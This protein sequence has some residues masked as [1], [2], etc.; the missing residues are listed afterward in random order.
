MQRHGTRHFTAYM[1]TTAVYA[2][3]A[4]LV[5][6]SQTHHFTSSE[7]P[8]ESVIKMSLSQFVPEILTPEPPEPIIEEIVEPIPE[9]VQEPEVVVEKEI[10]KEPEVVKEVVP[11][12]IVEKIVEKPVKKVVKKQPKPKKR[13]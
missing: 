8:K 1:I 3:A 13:L 12:P 9:P 4:F 5:Y 10:V 7:D 11:E 2:F 6:Y